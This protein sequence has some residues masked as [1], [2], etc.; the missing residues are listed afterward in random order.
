MAWIDVEKL[1]GEQHGLFTS[2]Q[3]V[4]RGVNRAMI[5]RKKQQGAIEQLRHGVYALASAP[6]DP[7]Q[8]I[9]AAWLSLEP[10]QTAVERIKNHEGPILCDTAAAEVYGAGVFYT[11]RYD[12]YSSTRK[13]SRDELIRVRLRHLEDEDIEMVDGILVVSPTVLVCDF[14]TEYYDL[15]DIT[16]LVRDLVDAQRKINWNRVEET[17]QKVSDGYGISAEEIFEQLFTPAL[18]ISSAIKS[19]DPKNE[20]YLPA[21]VNKYITEYWSRQMQEINRSL[22]DSI[23]PILQMQIPKVNV[24]VSAITQSQKLIDGISKNLTRQIPFKEIFMKNQKNI[25]N[26]SELIREA[27]KNNASYT[28]SS[29]N[30]N[31]PSKDVEK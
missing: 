3:A 11:D 8:E 19:T 14:L 27:L 17:A 28:S 20:R 23:K 5:T 25:Y 15:N 22:S 30:A 24:D 31:S 18:E 4:A 29:I 16:T 12:F 2:A 6:S 10:A 9:R 7:Y 1:A 26:A 21:E 13:Q